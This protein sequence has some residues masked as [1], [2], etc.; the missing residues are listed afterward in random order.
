[1]VSAPSRT[2]DCGCC[3]TVECH[4]KLHLPHEC[5]AAPPAWPRRASKIAVTTGAKWALRG[6]RRGGTIFAP[7]GQRTGVETTWTSSEGLTCRRQPDVPRGKAR[8]WRMAALPG[9]IASCQ[10]TEDPWGR[11]D[12]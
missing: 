9:S 12:A 1:M 8:C 2:T 7:G 6:T 10:G 5:G 4:G 11:K 3:C